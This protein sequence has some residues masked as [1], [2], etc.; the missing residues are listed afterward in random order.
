MERLDDIRLPQA[1]DP[2][3]IHCFRQQ[4][5]AL[6]ALWIILGAANVA[7]AGLALGTRIDLEFLFGTD[8]RAFWIIA[9]L[10]GLFSC[11]IGVLTCLKRLWA[12]YVSLALA[13]LTLLQLVLLQLVLIALTWRTNWGTI[14]ALGLIILVIRQGHRVIGWA[15]KMRAAG[16][17]LT[18]KAQS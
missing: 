15:K 13:Y 11:A 18:A 6:G 1:I 12:V 2:K 8:Q 4:I 14:V 7:L 3:L 9:G 10:V 17:P 5:H 16:V